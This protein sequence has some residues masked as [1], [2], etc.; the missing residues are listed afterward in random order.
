MEQLRRGVMLE[1]GLARAVR[2]QV[3][4]SVS[5]GAVVRIILLEG[6]QREVRRMMAALGCMVEQ[7]IRVRVGPLSLGDLKPGEHRELRPREVQ[8]LREC[9]GLEA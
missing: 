8:A 5:N 1:D 6:R 3:L 4:R 9:V 2:A 7:L